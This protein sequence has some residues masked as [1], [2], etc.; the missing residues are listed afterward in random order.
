MRLRYYGRGKGS[1]VELEDELYHQVTTFRDGTM[2]RV[3]YFTTWDQ[4]LEAAGVGR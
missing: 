4:A 2:V 1:G 3:E